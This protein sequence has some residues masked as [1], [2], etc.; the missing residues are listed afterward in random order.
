MASSELSEVSP[1]LFRQLFGDTLKSEIKGTA[2][3]Y[4]KNVG[5]RTVQISGVKKKIY[6][7]FSLKDISEVHDDKLSELCKSIALNINENLKELAFSFFEKLISE[8]NK[9]GHGTLI[10]VV[11][12]SK[13]ADVKKNMDGTFFETPIQ[14]LEFLETSETENSRQAS[15]NV[16]QYMSIVKSMINSDGI[17]IF[18]NKGEV[19]GYH[20]FV[21]LS[22]VNSG[23]VVGGARSRAF[24]AMKQIGL[25]DCCFFK[26]QDGNE[27][28]WKP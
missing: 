25:F 14:L 17:T 24:E 9:I 27:K 3:C 6:V 8:A 28:L 26:S 18:T 16:R 10:G 21:D 20:S 12:A 7:S 13:I 5:L 19:V 11:D 2:Y 15:T 23:T 4:I 22:K 1:S